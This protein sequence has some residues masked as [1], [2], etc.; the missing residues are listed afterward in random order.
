MK[1]END[2][3]EEKNVKKHRQFGEFIVFYLDSLL[4]YYYY[5]ML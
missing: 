3:R 4:Y 5:S 1:S 2:K